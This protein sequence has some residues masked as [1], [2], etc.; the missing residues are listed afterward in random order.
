MLDYSFHLIAKEENKS[1]IY[2]GSGSMPEKCRIEKNVF[3]R[4]NCT[5]KENSRIA[6]LKCIRYLIHFYNTIKV[7]KSLIELTQAFNPNQPI[8]R[9]KFSPFRFFIRNANICKKIQ[10]R[11]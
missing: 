9:N 5:T 6:W 7:L 2:K 11:Q 8:H 10:N 4:V 3:S 1:R